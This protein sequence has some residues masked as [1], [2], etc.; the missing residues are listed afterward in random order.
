[1]TLSNQL[2]ARLG[3]ISLGSAVLCILSLASAAHAEDASSLTIATWG[4]AYGQSQQAAY[5]QPFTE[6]TGTKIATVTYDGSFEAIKTKLGESPAPDVLDLSSGSLDRLC[7]DGLLE[8]MD[9]ATLGSEGGGAEDFIVG[10]LSSCGVASM[11]W[12]MALVVDKQSFP[13]GAPSK[14]ADLLDLK[15]YP[16]KRALSNGPRYTLE[17]ALLADGVT[18]DQV[19]A[20]LATPAGVDRAFAALDKI[21]PEIVWWNK[22]TEPIALLASKKAAIAV[23][24]SGRIFRALAG[25]RESMDLLW[26]GQIYDLDIW[27]VPKSAPNKD[28]AKRFIAFAATPE[29]LAAQARLIAYGPM[30]KSAIPLVGK[31]PEIGVEMMRFLPTAPENFKNALK[32]DEAWWN[33]HGGDLAKRFETWRELA[34]TAQ[35]AAPEPKKTQPQ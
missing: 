1:M 19:Y 14:I 9:P 33:E 28:A 17:F 13:K 22:A 32:F 21:K 35:G 15:A 24:Y 30:R 5:F 27:A 16:G 12:A 23:G 10:G 6:S 18:P 29:R 4:G 3:E 8:A 7:R 26:D 20:E 31:H 11:A 25:S 34:A 2:R